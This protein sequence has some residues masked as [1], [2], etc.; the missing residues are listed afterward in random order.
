[1]RTK[2]LFALLLL[3][4]ACQ[5]RP[6]RLTMES[7]TTKEFGKTK[8]GQAVELHTLTGGSG[9]VAKISTYGALLTEL[10]T[11]DRNGSTSDVVL[12]FDTLDGYLA[13]HPYFGAT[14]GRV[15]NRIKAGRFTLD[16][17]EYKLATNNGPNHLHGGE[18]GLDKR[19]W[20]V[21]QRGI[22]D[23][24]PAIR[25]RY[26]SPDGEEGYPGTVDISV[27]YT[28]TRA[29][30]LRIDYEATTDKATPLNLTNHSY[31]NLAGQGQGDILGH[32]LSIAAER[33][34]A[35][36]ATLIP[37]GELKA[38]KGTPFDFTSSTKLGAHIAETGGEPSGYDLNYVLN[39]GGGKLAFAARVEEPTSGRILEVETTEP[40]IQLYTGNFLDG[41]LKG[42]GGKVYQKHAAF[43]LETQHFPDSVNQ[44]SFPST[45][46]NPGETLRSTTVYRFSAK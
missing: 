12:G 20:R 35:T 32:V 24:G 38:V 31:F 6:E 27:T 4:A 43:C 3:S 34:T 19:V 45:I 28:V 14:T 2:V 26:K 11:S 7:I 1:M 46:L 37:T 30:A 44:P 23:N 25:F 39:S 36:D 9:L 21:E 22:T 33:M 8:E 15:A 29:N 40:G 10:W 5:S 41:T 16:G 18:K 42:K 13:G 17:K